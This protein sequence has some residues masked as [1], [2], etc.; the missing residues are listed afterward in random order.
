M[1]DGGR[2]QNYPRPQRRCARSCPCAGQYGSLPAIA[3]RAQKGRDAV[4]SYE[5]HSQ[6]RPASAAGL[7]W[8]PGRSAAHSHRAEPEATGQ[9]NLRPPA[10]SGS[11]V[12]NIH[13]QTETADTTVPKATTKTQKPSSPQGRNEFCNT[14]DGRADLEHSQ[15]EVSLWHPYETSRRK[16]KSFTGG[17]SPESPVRK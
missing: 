8:R 16:S 11:R 1:H 6:A 14:I 13:K 12:L 10:T 17:P 15:L 9:A 3:P 4:C 7:E 5:T 2:A